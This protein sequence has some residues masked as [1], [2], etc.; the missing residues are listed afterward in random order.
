MLFRLDWFVTQNKGAHEALS[1]PRA[2]AN[3]S[4]Y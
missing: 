3:K 2:P 1:F 4:L